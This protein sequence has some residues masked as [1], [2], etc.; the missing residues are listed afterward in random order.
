MAR[1]ICFVDSVAFSSADESTCTVQDPPL[2]MGGVIDGHTRVD[3]DFQSDP[4]RLDI[5]FVQ[6]WDPES[7]VVNF[8]VAVFEQDRSEVSRAP[9]QI[10]R[11]INVGAGTKPSVF[12]DTPLRAQAKYFVKAKAQNAAGHVSTC[13]SDGMIHHHS[14]VKCVGGGKGNWKR[15]EGEKV[16]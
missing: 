15:A 1:I 8:V 11:W 5:N 7:P 3:Q 13:E 10:S 12:F 16:R 6:I 9:T 4:L 14:I 2:C